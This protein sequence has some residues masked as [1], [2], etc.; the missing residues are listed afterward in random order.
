MGGSPRGMQPETSRAAAKKSGAG[1]RI[2]QPIAPECSPAP[3]ESQIRPSLL[4]SPGA[5]GYYGGVTERDRILRHL[6]GDFTEPIRD[7]LW[8]HIYLTPALMEVVTSP[9]FRKLSGIK[10]LGTAHLVYP[11]ATHTRFVHS[12]GV[13]HLAKRMI[14]PL[15]GPGNPFSV[16]LEGVKAFLC[17]ALLHDVGH[18]PFTHSLKEL[19]LKNHE[20]LTAELIL[21]PPLKEIIARQVG[22][23]PGLAA[24]MVDEEMD[25]GGSREVLFFRRVLSGALDPDKL[26]YLNRDA[27]F[28]GVPYGIQDTDFVIERIRSHPERG[29]ALD[30]SGLPAVENILFS[31]YLMYRSVYWHKTL[32]IATAMIKKAV[33]LG[34]T[35]GALAPEDLYGLDDEGF[36]R[37]VAARDFP[38]FGLVRRVAD[39]NLLKTAAAA[40]FDEERFGA[41]LDLNR[42]EETERRIA[43][44]ISRTSGVPVRPEEVVIDIPEK[45]SFEIGLPLLEPGGG[46]REYDEAGSV[47]SPPVVRNFSRVLRVLRI[48]LPP[49]AA[50]RSG[51]GDGL[52]A[53]LVETL[54]P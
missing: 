41:L 9:P 33:H 31:K 25:D 43:A 2:R 40:P 8:K 39:R 15:L 11:G 3:R 44:E 48:A 13:F 54:R 14:P 35:E 28:C 49:E 34:L 36:F 22:T 45:I 47:F 21:S 52:L 24:A 5:R 50:A 37:A 26:D 18:F 51:G 19:P 10:Q 27:W 46:T 53:L 17:A 32:R 12:L 23:D 38:P 4:Y 6:N 7:P 16:S 1:E 20:T 42:R 30:I 29:P